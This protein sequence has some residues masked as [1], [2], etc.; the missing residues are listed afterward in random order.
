MVVTGLAVYLAHPVHV[1][2][3]IRSLT[4]SEICERIIIV[5]WSKTVKSTCLVDLESICI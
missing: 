2:I 4:V 3:C 1:C 5:H